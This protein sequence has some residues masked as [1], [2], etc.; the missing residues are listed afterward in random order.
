MSSE[1]TP[2]T[3]AIVGAGAIGGVLADAVNRAGHEVVLCVRTPVRSLTVGRD[4]AA[5]VSGG[6]MVATLDFPLALGSS[7]TVGSVVLNQQH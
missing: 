3:V 1:S 7:A 5:Y 4:G 6:V 2:S